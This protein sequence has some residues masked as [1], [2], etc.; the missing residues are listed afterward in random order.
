MFY[1]AIFAGIILA[2]IGGL[3]W[4]FWPK[5]TCTDNRQN[6]QEQGVDCGGA[7]T[8]C[9][10]E[11]RDLS[12]L[13]VRFFKSREGFYDVAALVEN[14]NLHGGIPSIGYKFSL[15]DS[16]NV[17]IVDREGV[18]FINPGERQIISESNLSA[19]AR[20]PYTSNIELDRQKN[21]KYTEE[22]KSFLSIVKKVLQIIPFP[23]F[24]RN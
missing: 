3:I 9:L 6:G 13:W 10:G 21:W 4:Y 22:E 16:N 24:I 11:I 15:Y 7:C 17:S 20:I 14:S 12:V 5:P 2:L 18:T 1:F 23:P 19:G 8:P